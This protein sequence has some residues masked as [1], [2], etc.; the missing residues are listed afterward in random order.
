MINISDKAECNGCC[1][2]FDICPTNAISLQIDNE[3]FWYPEINKDLCTSCELCLKTCPE[4]IDLKSLETKPENPICYGAHY[5]DQKIRIDS[6]SGGLFSALANKM[7]DLGGY[8]AGAIY[9]DDFS[10][11]HIISNNRD[12]LEKLRSSKYL[13]SSCT[14]LYK[15]TKKLLIRGEKVL[16]CGCPCQMA[17]LRLFLSKEYENLIICDFICRGINSP[18]VFR[19]HL[20]SLEKQYDSKIVYVKAKNKELGWRKLTFKTIFEN[21]QSYYGDGQTDN[22]TRGYLRSGVYCRPSC[23]SCK[24]KDLPRIA[25]ITLADFW[26]IEKVNPELDNDTGTSVVMC[27]TPKGID[28]F[29]TIKDNLEYSQVDVKDIIPGNPSLLYSLKK[30]NTDREKFFKDLNQLTFN[31][32]ANKYFPLNKK[33]I[34]LSKV[35]RGLKNVLFPFYIMK[36]H[37]FLWLKFIWLNFLRKNTSSNFLKG[38]VII[39]TQ[40]CIFDIHRSAKINVKGRIHFGYKK[41]RGS[42]LETRIR[43]EKNATLNIEDIFTVFAG[44][45]IQLFQNSTMTLK[46]GVGAGCNIHCQIVCANE[47]SIGRNTLIGRNVVLR[48]YDAHYIIQKNYKV[49]APIKIGNHC[50]IGDGAM[51]SKGVSIGDGAIVAARSWVI[52]KV[53]SKTLVGGSPAMSIQENVQ[54]KI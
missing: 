2:C 17:A 31:K 28:F 53:P 24:F 48:D 49:S 7:Y 52:Q 3:G 47:I 32:V 46:G 41:V 26:G 35:K 16:V 11:K 51:I 44:A 8:V 29:N 9:N 14:N 27:N 6:T 40:C 20:D 21:G 25:D 37:P 45:D 34:L 38:H 12:D 15:D 19:K 13:Q 42:K 36:F 1:A 4:L 18:K 39:P 10:V 5:N 33:R 22:F 30:T 23:F 50:W 43:I 54:W